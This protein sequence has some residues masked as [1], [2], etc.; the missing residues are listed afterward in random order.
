MLSV[1]LSFSSIMVAYAKLSLS[2][3]NKLFN[4][5]FCDLQSSNEPEN[6]VTNELIKEEYITAMIQAVKTYGPYIVVGK[7]VA[8]AHARPEDGVNKLGLSIMTLANPICFG[9]EDN[10]PVKII[11]CLAAV[12]NFSH[13]NIM[14][15]IV[16]TINQEW[17][18]DQLLSQKDLENFKK[19]LF[20]HKEE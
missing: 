14:K 20:M 9:H 7:G 17:K 15:S 18:I 11:F 4:H 12:D 8:L 16:N 5:Y 19:I 13:L 3:S 6:I 1:I 2:K 10:D